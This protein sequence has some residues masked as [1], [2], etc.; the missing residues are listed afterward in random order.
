MK[1][2]KSEDGT[3][4]LNFTEGYSA[5]II[6]LSGKN[7][8]CLS[9]QVGCPMGCLFCVSGKRKFERNLSLSEL[10]GQ[11]GAA[12][13]YLEIGNEKLEIREKMLSDKISSI[14]FMG[15]GEPI[16]NLENVLE[17]CDWVNLEYGYAYSRILVSTCGLIP[18]MR[19]VVKRY[20]NKVQLAVSLHSPF[21]EIRDR[22]MPGLKGFSLVE[23]IEVM[24]EYNEVYRQ[25]IMVEYLMIEGLTDRDEDL[26]ALIQMGFARR[27]NFNLIP[28][29]SSFELDGEVMRS[30]SLERMEYFREKLMGAGYKCFTRKRFGE[31]IEA[32]CGMLK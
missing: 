4:K 26:A 11:L 16:A 19:E 17:F 12:L 5:V 27:T 15:M 8:L 1:V 14:V 2:E 13:Q 30:S 28:L 32:A 6:P 10:K 25:K 21:Q 29:N 20:P 23:L 22:I 7:T 24:N 9:S 3:V 18:G 31:D